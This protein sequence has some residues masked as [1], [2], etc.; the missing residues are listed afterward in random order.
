MQSDH[1]EIEQ[2]DFFKH[3]GD[4]RFF[5][6]GHLI[7]A[8]NLSFTRSKGIVDALG[9]VL[10][11]NESMNISSSDLHL[12]VANG[13]GSLRQVTYRLPEGANGY[14]DVASIDR[15][16]RIE[17]WNASYS[18]CPE[19][20]HDWEIRAQSLIIDRAK[21]DGIARHAVLRFMDVP[22]LYTPYISF[23]IEGR[24]SG[25]LAP[26]IG[27]SDRNG[28]DISMPYYVNLAPNYDLT[29]IPRRMSKRG[30]M[31]SAEAR[32]LS[33]QQKSNVNLEYLSD[34]LTHDNRWLFKVNQQSQLP[35]N[36]QTHVIYTNLSDTRY[37]NDLGDSFSVTGTT[38][39]EQSVQLSYQTEKIQFNT[40]FQDFKPLLNNTPSYSR[41][42]EISLQYQT[43]ITFKTTLDSQLT[44]FHH[45]DKQQ[46]SGLRL[47]LQPAVHYRLERPS[48]FIQPK[49]ALNLAKYQLEHSQYQP[50]RS[51]PTYSLDS[52]LFFEKEY[53]NATQT[54]EPRV[55]LQYTPWQDQQNVTLFD[56]SQQLFRY[57]SLFQSNRFVG[58]DCVG[59]NQRAAV[60]L[61]SR[62]ID[63]NNGNELVAIQVGHQAYLEK[64][65]IHLRNGE[66]DSS[67]A[68]TDPALDPELDSVVELNTHIG[69]V[70][71]SLT[72]IGSSLNNELQN[73][74]LSVQYQPQSNQAI[75]LSH[76]TQQPN[77]VREQILTLGFTW[78]LSN[79]WQI[80]S[81]WKQDLIQDKALE[82]NIGLHYESCCWSLGILAQ[83]YLHGEARTPNN[84]I[85]MQLELK[86][87]TNIN[88]GGSV[89]DII[90]RDILE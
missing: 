50:S 2:V 73:T 24:R 52:G 82:Q 17:L 30:S 65:R 53:A 68:P 67:D 81:S 6:N 13:T 75:K 41:L 66:C 23:P 80:F 36:W 87:L 84:S 11:R 85:M 27:N 33:K 32:Y 72:L 4:V 3:Y 16:N 51:L 56:S 78:P 42:P 5:Q 14:S 28:S 39:L 86:G 40:L 49:I 63:D 47:Y 57:N 7:E 38:H 26:E 77:Q 74:A 1:M 54:L 15:L 88:T 62:Y 90:Q 20:H 79:Q 25:L 37:I 18:Q 44:A 76:F 35:S 12:E 71:S 60:A 61:A 58:H 31:L 43:G 9:S 59:D 22:L 89:N 21:N 70:K 29:L 48:G 46:I 55:Y 10:Y 8:E 69:S 83:H 34:N 19:D 45:P 64:P